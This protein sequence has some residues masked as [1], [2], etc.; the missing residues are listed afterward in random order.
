M[1]KI[2]VILVIAILSMIEINAN[3][4]IKAVNNII[5][6]SQEKNITQEWHHGLREKLQDLK[7]MKRNANGLAIKLATM[8]KELKIIDG[9]SLTNEIVDKLEKLLKGIERS[10]NQDIENIRA[11]KAELNVLKD[12]FE[13]IY[14]PKN[15]EKFSSIVD[16]IFKEMNE[17]NLSL[18]EA[19]KIWE[20]C[21]EPILRFRNL[22]SKQEL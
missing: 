20:K 1:L 2:L 22:R 16:E 14:H 19:E 7:L 18:A 12:F 8:A 6:E 15:P 5:D 11:A 13:N 21:M 10:L 9:L 17:V 3:Q 4:S